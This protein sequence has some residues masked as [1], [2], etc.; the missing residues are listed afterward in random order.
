MIAFILM[1]LDDTILDFKK[2][3]E[4]AIRKT[5]ADAGVNPTEEICARYSQINEAHWKRL[6]KG[7][8]TRDQ[9]LR[10]R[11]E[12]LFWEL[13]V[14]A[15]AEK[16][17]AAYMENLSMGHYFLPGAKESVAKLS[18]KY[19]LYLASNGTASV[20][21]RR[22]ASAG[23]LPYFQNVFIS[24]DIG[25]NKPAKA[26]FDYCFTHIPGFD[27][28]KTMIVGDSLSSDI[29]GGIAAGITTCWVNLH[30]KPANPDIRPD[31]T[32]E[33]ITQLE[34]LLESL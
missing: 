21:Q 3:E 17:A 32:I 28:K 12:V 31:Y 13:G 8:L 1:D 16:A 24:Q 25:A 34:A 29:Q 2:Q 27:R 26:Y 30:N 11:F 33:S 19:K 14:Q 20:Q 4:V 15:D 7:E 6:E 5:L 18:K 10:G 22:L 23:I 9:V